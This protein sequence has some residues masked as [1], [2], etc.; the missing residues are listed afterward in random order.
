VNE[1]AEL[2]GT[3]T[4]RRGEAAVRE[5]PLVVHYGCPLEAMRLSR[6]HAEVEG[7]H[8]ADAWEVLLTHVD[9][10]GD[11]AA[12]VTKTCEKALDAWQRYRDGVAER[13]GLTRDQ[14]A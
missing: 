9:D 12:T 7:G 10:V 4:R 3:F 5:H 1:R 14:A 8:R 13:M 6:A 11:V 2:A